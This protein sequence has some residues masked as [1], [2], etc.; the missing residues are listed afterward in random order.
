MTCVT[1][2]DREANAEASGRRA[3]CTRHAKAK[4]RELPTSG[5]IRYMTKTHKVAK[6]IAARQTDNPHG[7]AVAKLQWLYAAWPCPAARRPD[8]TSNRNDQAN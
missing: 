6:R 4:R 3:M 5:L 2:W 7:R 1:Q 8:R